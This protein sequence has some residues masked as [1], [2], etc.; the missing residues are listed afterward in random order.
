MGD[1][2]ARRILRSAQVEEQL[3]VWGTADVVVGDRVT[4]AMANRAFGH[5]ISDADGAGEGRLEVEVDLAVGARGLE[6]EVGQSVGDGSTGVGADIES[7]G[8]RE[9]D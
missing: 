9:G 6:G 5:S 7:S 3:A 2:V 8:C 4:L 1:L